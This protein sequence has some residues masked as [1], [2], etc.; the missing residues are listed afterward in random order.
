MR[1]H[2]G[3]PK[4]WVQDFV[5]RQKFTLF[6]TLITSPSF[7]FLFMYTTFQD[8]LSLFQRQVKVNKNYFSWLSDGCIH[9]MKGLIITFISQNLNINNSYIILLTN[10]YGK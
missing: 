10:L 8:L 4:K 3:I 6:E 9:N 2:R 1:I 5:I 7:I